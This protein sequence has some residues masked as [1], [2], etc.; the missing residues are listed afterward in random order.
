MSDQDQG[1]KTE[2]ASARKLSQAREKGQVLSSKE[3]NNFAILLGATV[4]V[5]LVGPFTMRGLTE[6]L[7]IFIERPDMIDVTGSGAI[8]I[9]MLLGVG[10]AIAPALALLVVLAALGVLMQIGWLMSPESIQPKL[11]KISPISGAKRLFSLKSVVELLK[12]IVK[13]ILVG[14]VAYLI[15]KPE[16]SRI[17]LMVQMDLKELLDETHFV[18]IEIFIGVL[19]VAAVIAVVDYLYQRYEFMNQMKMSKQEVRDEHKQTEGDPHVKARLRQL[20][21]ERARTRMMAEVP[22]ATVVITNPTH[23]AIAL[24]YDMEQMA[25]P[26]VVAKGVDAVALRIREIANENEVPMVENRPL[27][28]ALYD[29][30]ELDEEIPEDYYKAVA[31]VISYVFKMNQ[32]YVPMN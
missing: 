20:R 26:R 1:D 22:K 12:G 15:V 30:A 7:L 27:A 14:F 29:N 24:K 3:V 5:G 13:M 4:V 19:A 8:M 16:F 11:E 21:M 31:E 9:D 6:S 25:A 10:L 17:D 18:A 23:Y 32:T 2:E 28:R